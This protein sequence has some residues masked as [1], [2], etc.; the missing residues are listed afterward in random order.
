MSNFKHKTS[1]TI[2]S[3]QIPFDRQ[4]DFPILNVKIYLVQIYTITKIENPKF[5]WC[6]NHNRTKVLESR[7]LEVSF[8][9]GSLVPFE[10]SYLIYLAESIT[11]QKEH[12]SYNMENNLN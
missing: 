5:L 7:R 4:G 3:Y 8:S 6:L 12:E 1:K 11:K 9:H 2:L 10:F